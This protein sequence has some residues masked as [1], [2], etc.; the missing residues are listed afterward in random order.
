MHPFPPKELRKYSLEELLIYKAGRGVDVKVIVWQP[1]LLFRSLPG[2]DDRGIDGRAE[3]IEKMDRNAGSLGSNDNL[4][5]LIDN[6]SPTFTSAHHEKL[7]IVDSDLAFCGGIELSRGKW[8]TSKHAYDSPLR[9]PNSEPWHDIGVLVRG[10]VVADL[11][12]HF[13]QRWHHAETKDASKVGKMRLFPSRRPLTT[14]SVSVIALRTWKDFERTSGIKTWYERL[15]RNAKFSIYIENQFPFQDDSITDALV[16]RL[17]DNKRLK[18]VIVAPLEPNLPGLVGKILSG[19]SLNDVNRNLARLRRAGGD[20]VRTY[21]LITETKTPPVKRRQIYVHSK[22]MIVDDVWILVGS[23]NLDKNGMKD[24]SEV[25]LAIKSKELAKNLRVKLWKE[26]TRRHANIREFFD[27]DIG[28]HVLD[29]VALSNGK[30]ILEN[31]PI[32]GHLYYYDFETRGAPE[33]YDDAKSTA[34]LLLP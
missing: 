12:Y 23:A 8:D 17:E 20:R 15:F 7:I 33:P 29:G 9:D 11:E 24:S 4:T 6:T 18:V 1:R 2:A 16:E 5:V 32:V 21:C 22:L 28:F 25:N 31:K 30:R 19:V 14:G 10:P 27:P 26:H 13:N 3:E 34:K